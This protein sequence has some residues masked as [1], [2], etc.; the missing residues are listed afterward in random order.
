MVFPLQFLGIV[1]FPIWIVGININPK[2]QETS[3]HFS[4]EINGMHLFLTAHR[5]GW[6]IEILSQEDHTSFSVLLNN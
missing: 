3:S 6:P 5:I 2:L 1:N 4:D